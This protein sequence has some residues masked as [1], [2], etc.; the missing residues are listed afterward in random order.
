MIVNYNGDVYKC[1][2]RDFAKTKRE[3]K[4]NEDGTITYEES[5]YKRMNALYSNKTCQECIIFPICDVCSQKRLEAISTECLHMYTEK[6]KY[7]LIANCV[8][9]VIMR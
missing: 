7:R 3:G 1:T 2:A 5:Y 9:T 8:K 6:D 4:L